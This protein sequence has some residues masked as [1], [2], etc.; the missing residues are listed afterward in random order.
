MPFLLPI[1]DRLVVLDA[2][3]K[4]LEGSP[5]E[6]QADGRV[7]AAYLGERFAKMAAE[8]RQAEQAGDR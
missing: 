1:S 6:V 8:T 3:Q 5:D 7:I 4:I 2:G